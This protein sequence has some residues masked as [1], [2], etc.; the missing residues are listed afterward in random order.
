MSTSTIR[1]ADGNNTAA[2]DGAR[3]HPASIAP[4]PKIG[5]RPAIPVQVAGATS[6]P[7]EGVGDSAAAG[8]PTEA[9]EDLGA[10]TAAAVFAARPEQVITSPATRCPG[11]QC[12]A[13][14]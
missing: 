8:G 5:P 12:P 10:V 6:T 2:V 9:V 1:R 3:R 13:S 14:C 7:E 11:L 4:T